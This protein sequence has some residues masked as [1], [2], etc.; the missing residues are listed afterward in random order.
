MKA[1]ARVHQ[2]ASGG[3]IYS[4]LFQEKSPYKTIICSDSQL[5]VF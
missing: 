1:G 3:G 2:Q 4:F 5:L